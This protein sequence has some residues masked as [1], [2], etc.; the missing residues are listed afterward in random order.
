MPNGERSE[1]RPEVDELFRQLPDPQARSRL[2]EEFLPLAEHIARRFAG[3][4]EPVDDLTQ[5]A[6]LGLLHAIDRFDPDRG[7]H[8]ATYAS[9][10][11]AGE[12]KRHFRDKGWALRMPRGLQEAGLAVNRSLRDLWQEL[13]R[14]PTVA[15]VA[16]RSGLSEEQVLEAMEAVQS[17][18][19]ASLDAPIGEDGLTHGDTLG[20]IDAAFEQAEGWATIAE[21]VKALPERERRILYLRFFKDMTQSEIAAEVGI[22][23]MH[24]SRMLSKTIEHLRTEANPP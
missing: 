17:Y 8:F 2:V 13:G 7:V 24:V 6:G 5:V 19:T 4:G 12:L 23:Q 11:I 9:A 10:T 20:Q 14:S 21:A 18:S 16:T 15:E 3:R 22:S 1:D